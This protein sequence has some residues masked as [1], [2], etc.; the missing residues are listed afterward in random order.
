MTLS[1]SFSKRVCLV[2]AVLIGLSG[3][4]GTAS[5]SQGDDPA[6]EGNIRIAVLPVS[7]LSGT[8]APLKDLRQAL[9]SELQKRGFGVIAEETLQGFLARHHVRNLGGIDYDTGLAFK[10]ET[11]ADAVLITTLGLYSD[12]K[13]PRASVMSRLVS[14][15]TDQRIRWMDGKGMAGDDSPGILGL[16]LIMDPRR[17]LDKIARSLADSL[18]ASLSGS[19]RETGTPGKRFRPKVA[20]R[21]P[22]FSPD[23]HYRI[24]VVPFYDLSGRRNAGELMGLQ[25]MNALAAFGSFDVIEP[26]VLRDKMLRYRVMLNHGVSLVNADTLFENLQAD[27]ILTGTVFDFEDYQGVYGRPK[28]SFSVQLIDRASREVV[29]SSSS[30]NEGDDGV[31]F[32]VV[33]RVNTAQAMVSRMARLVV[34]MMVEK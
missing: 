3:C 26:G 4:A 28:A 10:A 9:I 22:V 30:Y 13:P 27:L 18:S 33:G 23:R 1:R 14:T 16:G 15:G 29:W 2:L 21:S 12:R 20:Y 6:R 19:G 7:N 34:E 8:A 17:L 24:V 25:F 11:G 32:F 31:F 5:P